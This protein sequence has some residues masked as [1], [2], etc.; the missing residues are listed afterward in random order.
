MDQQKSEERMSLEDVH[1]LLLYL[2]WQINR[3]SEETGIPYFAHAGTLIGVLR[4]K[5]FTPW[6]D[7]V[8]LLME[9]KYYGDFVAACKKLFPPEVVVRTREDDPYFCEEYIKICFKDDVCQYSELAVDIFLLDETDPSRKTFRKFQNGI[10]RWVRPVKLYKV[11]RMCGY[12]KPYIPKKKAARI[13]LAIASFLPLK[14]LTAIQSWAMTAEKKKTDYFVDWGSTSGYQRAT[15]PKYFFE[16]A[17]K[18]PFENGYIYASDRAEEM[19][20]FVFKKSNWRELP[21]PEKRKSHS[22][23]KINNPRID[24]EKIKKETEQ[25]NG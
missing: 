23:H 16:H 20:D 4:H 18:M 6:D 8:D 2:L 11:S 17:Q 19:A 12:M 1:T 15:R 14:F 21:P 25:N 22:V 13:L 3:V 9:R 5:G 7:D 24:I 10:I